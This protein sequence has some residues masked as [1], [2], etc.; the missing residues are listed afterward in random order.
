[1]FQDDVKVIAR[2]M[3][4]GVKRYII[5]RSEN[6]SKNYTTQF[7]QQLFAEEGKNEF[8]TRVNILGHA[9]QGG[10]PSPFDRNSGKSGAYER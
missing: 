4:K 6:A 2:K 8:S 10:S 1:M 7:I 9:Q 3:I 5:V